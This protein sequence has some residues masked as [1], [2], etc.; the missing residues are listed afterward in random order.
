[1]I[2]VMTFNLRLDLEMDGINRFS[3]RLS[4]ITSFLLKEKPDVVYFQEVTPKMYFSL[5][6]ILTDYVSVGTFRRDQ[7]E[8]TPIFYRKSLGASLEEGTF[9]LTSTPEQVSK[10]PDSY[11]YRIASYVVVSN[12]KLPPIAFFN[13]H[14]DYASGDVSTRQ[15]ECVIKRMR[16]VGERHAASFVLG[17]DFNQTP[18]TLVN[19][20]ISNVRI[21]NRQMVSAYQALSNPGLTYH[22]FTGET[23]GEPIDFL[24]VSE[25]L[26]FSNVQIYHNQENGV[27]LSDH[28]PLA[29][30]LE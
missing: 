12:A 1:M 4:F 18:N 30:T 8:A 27:Y 22:G 14:L 2:R 19:Q 25:E 6:H 23:K 20:F 28:Y 24:Y 7:D 15:M 5:Q 11:F 21:Q 3:N 26:T 16:E 17:G 10:E 29:L 9:W 13:T